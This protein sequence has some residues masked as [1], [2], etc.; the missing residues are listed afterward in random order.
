MYET[1][2]PERVLTI[3]SKQAE[4]EMKCFATMQGKKDVKQEGECETSHFAVPLEYSE[5][6]NLDLSK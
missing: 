3:L 4:E 6:P 5:F 1:S 2:F